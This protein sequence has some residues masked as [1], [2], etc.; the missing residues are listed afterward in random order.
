VSTAEIETLHPKIGQ[1]IVEWGFEPMPRL[2]SSTVRC[3]RQKWCAR[4]ISWVSG[5]NTRC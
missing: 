1:L 3:A 4:I 5:V 2:N